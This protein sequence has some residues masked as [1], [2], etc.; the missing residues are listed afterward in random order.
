MRLDNSKTNAKNPQDA[1]RMLRS[2]RTL[3]RPHGPPGKSRLKH[4]AC[5]TRFH[6]QNAVPKCK[7]YI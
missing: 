7:R 4:R 3:S 1:E 5:S 2:S 6:S